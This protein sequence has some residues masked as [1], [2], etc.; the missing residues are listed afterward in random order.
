MLDTVGAELQVV[1]KNEH[2]ISLEANGSV[3][4]TPHKDNEATS[5]LLPINFTGLS[6]VNTRY[7]FFIHVIFINL[8]INQINR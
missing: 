2:A 1:N 3:V 8:F 4:L 7:L 5:E 6:K